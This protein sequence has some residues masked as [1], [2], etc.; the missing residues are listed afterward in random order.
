MNHI[1][2][3][4]K[5]FNSKV[6]QLLNYSNDILEILN[7]EANVDIIK[8]G[9]EDIIDVIEDLRS[10]VPEELI[11]RAKEGFDCQLDKALDEL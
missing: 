6:S 8:S 3:D 7:E 10:Y 2:I 1:K 11:R 5:D 4:P 9:M